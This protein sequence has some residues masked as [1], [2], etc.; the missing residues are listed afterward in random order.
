MVVL[1]ETDK[2]ADRSASTWQSCDKTGARHDRNYLDRAA[3]F[4]E[5]EIRHMLGA[6]MTSA[7]YQTGQAGDLL[8]AVALLHDLPERGLVRGQ[9]GTIVEPL[10]ESTAMLS[11]ATTRDA[12][13]RS[14]R[15]HA[16]LC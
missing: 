5:P 3:E 11:S 9:V 12:P 15:A 16:R 4:A 1:H 6:A 8:S 13:T 7:T 14:S 2:W 10:D